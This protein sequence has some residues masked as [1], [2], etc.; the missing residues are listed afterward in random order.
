MSFTI[1][2]TPGPE[3][4]Q[5]ALFGGRLHILQRKNG[6]RFSMDAVLLAK[7]AT[8]AAGDRI[9]DLGTGCG[10]VSLVLALDPAPRCIVG[11]EVQSDLASLARKNVRLN[12]MEERIEIRT[13]DLKS[14][15]QWYAPESFDL[16]VV[17]PPF[18]LP[19]SGRMNPTAEKA[20]ARHEI[21]GSLK[22]FLRSAAF[23][24]RFSGK[25]TIIYR[26][27]RLAYL[28]QSLQTVGF[29]PKRLRMVHGR[30]E[31]PAKMVLLTATKGGGQE[32]RVEPP[33][34]LFNR[35]GSYSD[36]LKDLYRV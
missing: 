26:A 32:L 23:L 4:T 27:Q 22:D 30:M 1:E 6:Y 35:D 16:A 11:L 18:G 12:G 33:L 10:V 17:N 31:T 14:V 36:E 29:T 13:G 15:T 20:V 2:P 8:P 5:D 25:L 24:V 3:E 34:I 9:I 7:F 21:L 28:F 19:G